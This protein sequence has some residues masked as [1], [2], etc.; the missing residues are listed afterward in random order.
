L[1]NSK[2][3]KIISEAVML[4]EKNVRQSELITEDRTTP[5]CVVTLFCE[6]KM[7]E[8]IACARLGAGERWTL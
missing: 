1:I 3:F 4:S 2:I 6:V 8:K 7:P 5:K